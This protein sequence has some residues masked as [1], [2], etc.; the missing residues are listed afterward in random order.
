M[1]SRTI[2]QTEKAPQAIGPYSQAIAMNQ[3]LF[4]AGQIP[5]DPVTMEIVAGGIEEQT[6]QVLV[7][8]KS[9]I[10]AG[11]SSLDQVLKTTVF[12]TDLTQFPLMNQVYTKYFGHSLPARSTVQVAALPK[13]SLVEIEAI[14]FRRAL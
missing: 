2:V 12:M 8:L 3:L 13:N 14:A 4:T 7:N 10:E 6:E 1:N 5:L 9:V 11:G